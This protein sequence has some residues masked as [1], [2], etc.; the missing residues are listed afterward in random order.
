MSCSCYE[1]I[2]RSCSSAI[3]LIAG[4]TA[5][6]SY[7]WLLTAPSGKIYQRQAITDAEGKLLIDTSFLP[8]G[9]LNSNAGYFN[10]EIRS[11]VN[12]LT[13][14]DLTLGGNTYSCVL[15]KFENIDAEPDNLYN[16]IE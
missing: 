7:Y 11:G 10:L 1:S 4:L 3:T 13:K 5:T 15:I 8:D 12:Y 14:V 9:L 2:I 6:T 16:V